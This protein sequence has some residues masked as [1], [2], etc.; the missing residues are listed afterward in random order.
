VPQC[1]IAGD[2]NAGHRRAHKTAETLRER[3]Y[4][5]TAVST[6]LCRCRLAVLVDGEQLVDVDVINDDDA[7]DDGDDDQQRQQLAVDVDVCGSAARQQRVRRVHTSS[8]QQLTVHIITS[9][10]HEEHVTTRQSVTDG[11]ALVIDSEVLVLWIQVLVG[12]TRLS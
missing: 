5:V 3:K 12:A 1:P 4:T 8:T 11:L 7:D 6:P 9:N 10:D 2:A